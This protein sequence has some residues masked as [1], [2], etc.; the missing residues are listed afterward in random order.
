M[1]EQ[2]V[3]DWLAL[4]IHEY[5]S[6]KHTFIGCGWQFDSTDNEGKPLC[7]CRGYARQMLAGPNAQYVR[8]GAAT[9]AAP[10]AKVW[11]ETEHGPALV[12]AA[13]AFE[14]CLCGPCVAGRYVRSI[15]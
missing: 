15:P 13:D 3:E 10:E 6:T 1:T 12:D 14:T 4:L 11:V 5:E 2:S 8:Q 7:P 9:P